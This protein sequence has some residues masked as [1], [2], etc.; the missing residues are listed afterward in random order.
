[1]LKVRVHPSFAI[2][3]YSFY[4]EGIGRVFG[5]T[6]IVFERDKALEKTEFNDGFG[7]TIESDDVRHP[8]YRRI[9]I[10]ANDFARY[11]RVAL[12]WCDRYGMINHDPAVA[13]Q[14][15]GHEKVVPI[16]SSFGLRE[17]GSVR[18]T[19]RDLITLQRMSPPA[20]RLRDRIKITTK[21]LFD[22]LPERRYVP[23]RS[24][25][26]YVFFVS[27]P[28]KKHP[29]VNP[30]RARFMRACRSVPGVRFEGGF[31]PR[32]RRDVPGIDDVLALRMYS[33]REWVRLTQASSVVFNCPAVHRC[34]GWKLGEFLALGK[35]IL[36]LPLSREMPSPLVHGE[37]VH[38]V[39]DDQQAMMEGIARIS[40]DHAYRARLEIAARQY[41]LDYLSPERVIQRLAFEHHPRG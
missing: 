38:Y 3:Y 14:H 12:D 27:W 29:E 1:M 23:G 37:H 30:P 40:R 17:W 25:P 5:D 15:E 2:P 34:L 32:R 21:Q 33:F 18:R 8:P 35:A 7:F 9:Y 20:G 10:S 22:R 39:D 28:W 41:Y 31:P 19:A 36:S 26:D 11:D 16:G 6:S 4:L 24:R 13:R